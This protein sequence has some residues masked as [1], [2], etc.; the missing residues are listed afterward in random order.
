MNRSNIP[1][2]LR[3]TGQILE[4][5]QNVQNEQNLIC[6]THLQ[7]IFTTGSEVRQFLK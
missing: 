2:T 1:N 3:S 6:K 7:V 4:E 5:V